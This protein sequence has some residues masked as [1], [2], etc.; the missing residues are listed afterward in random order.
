MTLSKQAQLAGEKLAAQQFGKDTA[1]DAYLK[2]DYVWGGGTVLEK[3]SKQPVLSGL[4]YSAYQRAY[5]SIGIGIH[6]TT[7]KLPVG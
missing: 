5:Q 4:A 7:P 2:D 6:G 3:Y 1:H